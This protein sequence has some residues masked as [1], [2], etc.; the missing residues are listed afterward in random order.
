MTLGLVKVI[1]G[2]TPDM[3]LSSSTSCPGIGETKESD[4]VK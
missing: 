2:M 3:I 4:H 1:L